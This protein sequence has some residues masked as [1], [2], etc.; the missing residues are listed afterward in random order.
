MVSIEQ[1]LFNPSITQSLLW[2]TIVMTIGLWL[3]EKAKI[4][5]FSLGVTWVLFIGIA[6]ASLGVNID[7]SVAQFAKDFG[8]ILF[9]YSIGL[10]VGPSF[11]P[12]K[13]N[14]LQLNML[15]AAVVLLGCVCTIVLHYITGIDMSTLAGVMS[16]ATTSTPSLAAAQQAYFDL[17]GTSNPDIATGYAVAYPLSIVGVIMAFELIRKSFNIRLPEE[18]KRLQEAA[19]ESAEEPVCVDITLNN[20]QLGV[21]NVR[22]LQRVCPVIKEMVVSRVI[23]PNGSDEIINED[24]IFANGD[25]I[26]ILTDRRH[27][28][29]LRL[30]GQMK[31]YDL[32]VQ[33]E[34]SNHLI[35]RRI[36]VTRPECNGKR[37]RSFNLRQQYHATITRVNRAGIDLLATP[38]MILQ[39]GDR[40]MV[41]GD[42]EDVKRVAD[43]FG[44]EL[45]RLDLPN[46]LPVFFGMVLGICVGLLPIPMPGLGTTFKLGLAGGS[47]IV[48]ILIGHYG[49]YYNMVT[50]STTSANMMLRQVGLT[51]FLAALG[52]SVGENFVPTVVNGGYLWIGYGFLITLIPLVII[53]VIAYKL[54]HINY[55]NVVGLMIGSMTSAMSLPYA[56]SLSN[57]NNQASIC[58]A[59]VYP[60][61][62]FL[63]VMAAQL[64]VLIFCSFTPPDSIRPIRLP[65]TVNTPQGEEYGPTLTIDDNTL[66]FVGLNR[67]DGSYTEDVYVSRRDARTGEWS[68]ARRVEAGDVGQAEG[69]GER[70][71]RN[72]EVYVFPSTFTVSATL[73]SSSTSAVIYSTSSVT[74]PVSLS[75]RQILRISR[76]FLTQRNRV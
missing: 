45:K 2:L 9:V 27:L 42:K 75:T 67:E 72:K 34:K 28:D 53:G 30:L 15:A 7:H 17:T 71:R 32:R 26:R 66:Y 21:L 48:A 74:L 54:L 43:T 11:S 63:R 61:T 25:I 10:Q 23:R 5:N 60:F 22:E 46:L 73:Y 56:Q 68:G 65:A 14:G 52:L 16:G 58:Y 41:V 57:E 31:D 29:V 55:F 4:K 49:P 40:L 12:F 37:I 19:R 38:D 24:T 36:A 64:L 70:P 35:S 6:L 44:N 18:E 50:F 69:S 39:L 33:S 13:K 51:L 20:P 3:G 8:L 1:F 76:I 47:L 59:T 62:T